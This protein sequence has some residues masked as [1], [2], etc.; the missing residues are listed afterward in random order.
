MSVSRKPAKTSTFVNIQ[1][2]R[3]QTP[4]SF[5]NVNQ[6]DLPVSVRGS[7][8]NESSATLYFPHF[9]ELSTV[10]GFLTMG[11]N[12]TSPFLITGRNWKLSPNGQFAEMGRVEFPHR[13]Y[14]RHGW[15]TFQMNNWSNHVFPLS[16]GDVGTRDLRTQQAMHAL[17]L[18]SQHFFPVHQPNLHAAIISNFTNPVVFVYSPGAAIA[19]DHDVERAAK[20]R[21]TGDPT[22]ENM[23]V[24]ELLDVISAILSHPDCKH[25]HHVV[26]YGRM[27]GVEDITPVCVG[28]SVNAINKYIYTHRLLQNISNG[29]PVFQPPV[30]IYFGS[31]HVLVPITNTA[32]RDNRQ[33]AVALNQ[34]YGRQLAPFNLHDWTHNVPYTAIRHDY[35]PPQQGFLQLLA[36]F[37]DYLEYEWHIPR[38]TV[39]FADPSIHVPDSIYTQEIL[40]LRV[41]NSPRYNAFIQRVSEIF[42]TP[43]ALL[44]VDHSA[45]PAAFVPPVNLLPQDY[46]A[47]RTAAQDFF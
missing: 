2:G 3:S 15:N 25:R 31:D 41:E 47:M 14:F 39:Q 43:L 20:S 13:H 22:L 11:L 38:M 10:L 34:D 32:Y 9:E 18:N 23:F 40:R 6:C 5:Q 29:S 46:I 27:F 4:I 44:D 35:F 30:I 16:Q 1:E 24:Y 36:N 7:D 8:P 26:Q 19:S 37:C 33:H 12:F 28:T 45:P 21:V 17:G 42:H